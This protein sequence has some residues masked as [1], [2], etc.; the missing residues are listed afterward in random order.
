MVDLSAVA[1]LG[2]AHVQLAAPR[3]CEAAAR[4]FYGD[5]LGMPELPKPEAIRGR[6]GVW[7]AAGPQ[8]LHVGVEEPFAP[9]RKAHPGLVV[10]D[11]DAVRARLAEAGHEP[12]DDA[13]IEGVRRFFVHDPFGNRLEVRQG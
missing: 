5:L 6:G 10:D 11:F 9:A 1:V 4:A 13:K 8:E 3:G 2:V 12:E 7:F